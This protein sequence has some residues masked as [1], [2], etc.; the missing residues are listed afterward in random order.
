MISLL[1]YTILLSVAGAAGIAYI[2]T[3]KQSKTPR[4]ESKLIGFKSPLKTDQQERIMEDLGIQVKEY[5]PLAD[6]Y[7]CEICKEQ[8]QSLSANDDIEFIEDDY[9][10]KIQ[11]MPYDP[12]IIG[13]KFKKKHKQEIPWGIEK[14]GANSVWKYTDGRNVKVGIIDT[15]VEQG[16]PDLK[17]NIALAQGVISP[18]LVKDDNGHGTHIAG[19]I[20]ALNNNIGVVGVAP[21]ANIFSVKAFDSYGSGKV[22]DII[23][24]LEWCV[25]N[26]VD[27]INMS[28]G[29]NEQ[30]TAFERAIRQTYEHNIVLVA[31]S[32]NSGGNNSVLYPAKYPQVIAVAASNLGDQSASFS[33]GGPEVDVIAP[34]ENILSTYLNSKYKSLSGT[35]MAAPHVTG[36][37]AL[38]LST[39]NLKP[40]D[41]KTLIKDTA[42]DLG[43]PAEKQGAG[44]INASSAIIK[45]I[46][47]IRGLQ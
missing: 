38:I 41:V 33:S 10:V 7:L 21:K 39:S 26:K 47:T 20:A 25:D 37:V 35:S 45:I 29:I 13:K 1:L 34:G 16:H 11:V 9:T 30:S 5:L 22:S 32:G 31:A 8:V 6:A 24:A 15:G 19:T 2:Q 46:K 4:T 42:D 40:E 43:L 36:L 18:N 28:F 44:R 14:I 3:A 12:L 17:D 27:V 23:K